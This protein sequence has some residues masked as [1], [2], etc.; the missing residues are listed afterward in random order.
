[1]S[2]ITAAEV[3]SVFEWSYVGGQELML[4]I[5]EDCPDRLRTH[6]EFFSAEIE[7]G[8]SGPDQWLVELSFWDANTGFRNEGRERSGTCPTLKDAI[9]AVHSAFLELFEEHKEHVDKYATAE[10]NANAAWAD[11]IA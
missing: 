1:M 6:A 11:A 8:S 7:M 4:K 5:R 2:E 9:K 3:A 10:Q